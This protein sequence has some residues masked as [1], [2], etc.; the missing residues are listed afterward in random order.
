MQTIDRF[1]YLLSTFFYIPVVVGLIFLLLFILFQFG[2]F[3][4]VAYKRL[5]DKHSTTTAYIARMQQGSAPDPA[6]TEIALR[7]LIHQQQHR[8][9]RKIQAARYC[10]K[11]GPTAGLI[12]TL[13]PMAKALAGLSQGDLTSLAGQMIT[14]FSTTVLGLIIGGIGYS[15]A[16]VRI[17]WQQADRYRLELEAEHIYQN[18]SL[19]QNEVS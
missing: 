3:L 11:I 16:H 15:I 1:L 13:T 14:A 6:K 10:V 18:H 2:Q 9:A 7:V 4:A 17:K 5:R 8:N 12:G 19:K